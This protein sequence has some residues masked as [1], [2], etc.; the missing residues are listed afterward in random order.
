MGAV[1]AFIDEQWPG[2][3]EEPWF[4]DPFELMKAIDRH[5]HRELHFQEPKTLKPTTMLKP[6]LFSRRLEGGRAQRHRQKWKMRRQK[7]GLS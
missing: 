5:R 1:L 6:Q 7:A 3:E 4:A 2:V